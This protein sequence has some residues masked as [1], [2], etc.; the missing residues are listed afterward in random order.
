M[1]SETPLQ[2]ALRWKCFEIAEALIEGG[3]SISQTDNYGS[4]PLHAAARNGDLRIAEVLLA[5]GVPVDQTDEY[6]ETPLSSAIIGQNSRKTIEFLLNRRASVNPTNKWGGIPLHRAAGKGNCE[7]IEA[8]L[9]AG[10]LANINQPDK[11]GRTPLYCAVEN[12]EPKAVKILLDYRASL[13][14]TDNYGRTLLHVARNDEVIEALLKAGALASINQA[15]KSGR[16][17]LYC[18][19]ENGKLTAVKI[20]LGYRASMNQT[21]NYG[22]T[23]LHAAVEKDHHGILNILL[24]DPKGRA[25]VN[26]TNNWGETP[27]DW[28]FDTHGEESVKIL[29]QAGALRGISLVSAALHN[30][31]EQGSNL[32]KRGK[33]FQEAK[34]WLITKRSEEGQSEK[35][36]AFYNQG[37]TNLQLIYER[38]QTELTTSKFEKAET[39][40]S[41]HAN[42]QPTETSQSTATQIQLAPYSRMSDSELI[43]I[44]KHLAVKSSLLEAGL[45]DQQEE[46]PTVDTLQSLITKANGISMNY[47][48]DDS[49]LTLLSFAILH[50]RGT[51]CRNIV[52]TLL[53]APGADLWINYRTKEGYTPLF[54]AALKKEFD[55]GVTLLH[56][57]A[58]FQ[59]AFQKAETFLCN[60]TNKKWLKSSY[61][62]DNVYDEV[63]VNLQLINERYQ[64]ELAASK[65]GTTDAK[66]ETN[67]DTP[68]ETKE[69][70]HANIQTTES[71]QSTAQIQQIQNDLAEGNTEALLKQLQQPADAGSKMH[72][73]LQQEALTD[74]LYA[75]ADPKA[76]SKDPQQAK[77]KLVEAMKTLLQKDRAAVIRPNKEEDGLTPLDIALQLDLPK[78]I[79]GKLQ[80]A[81]QAEY[82]LQNTEVLEKVAEMARESKAKSQKL[83][84]VSKNKE[85][86]EAEA[87]AKAYADVASLLSS[88]LVKLKEIRDQLGKPQSTS[89]SVPLTPASTPLTHTA[90]PLANTAVGLSAAQKRQIGLGRQLLNIKLTKV[91]TEALAIKYKLVDGFNQSRV[92]TATEGGLKLVA[93]LL[94]IP[95]AGTMAKAIVAGAKKAVEKRDRQKQEHRLGEISTIDQA[96]ERI[97]ALVKSLTRRFQLVFARLNPESLEIFVDRI[98]DRMNDYWDRLPKR[99]EKSGLSPQ[100]LEQLLREGLVDGTKKPLPKPSGQALSQH[101]EFENLL[102]NMLLGVSLCKDREIKASNRLTTFA[103]RLATRKGIVGETAGFVAGRRVNYQT[104]Q[105][106][107]EVAVQHICRNAPVITWAG[108]T[109][110]LDEPVYHDGHAPADIQIDSDLPSLYLREKECK[111][112][113][114]TVDQ[115]I[116]APVALPIPPKEFDIDLMEQLKQRADAAE[117][118]AAELEEQ[119]EEVAAQQ[120]PLRQELIAAQGRILELEQGQVQVAP[121][122]AKSTT[123]PRSNADPRVFKSL[124]SSSPPVPGATP[125]PPSPKQPN[126]PSSSTTTTSDMP[127][128]SL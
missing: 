4:P 16:T 84:A 70:K 122:D 32:L 83:E 36:I 95:L 74:I 89:S 81:A 112:R 102:E 96:A 45:A 52:K 49:G 113:G 103:A 50:Y 106:T 100:A 42:T 69:S 27:L 82:D 31:F 71:S 76:E 48:C 25:L 66:Q 124:A 34:D 19:V 8:L 120:R 29:L 77:T 123:P 87:E 9:K 111:L 105:G 55:V 90:T 54:F 23:L 35:N 62:I 116:T 51:W 26:Q 6:G 98:V 97:A 11:S 20:L 17:P 86:K 109:D 91:L 64:A 117:A 125:K 94:P 21:D 110:D 119:V 53:I 78:E 57:G 47:A 61:N 44:L 30:H 39:K 126:E 15:D 65:S 43:N 67:G 59:A 37:L 75:Q 72:N 46:I 107:K 79:I 118:R 38:Y 1:D 115:S 28:A 92:G 13:S 128:G 40:E 127:T 58:N 60:R 5:K 93:D 10:A 114:Y 121:G 63:L 7:A 12:G 88:S 22:H 73:Y 101:Q 18:A 104:L 85:A 80:Q 33:T 14:Q 2:K 99:A 41:K 56:Y 24:A 108:I 68:P 3:A